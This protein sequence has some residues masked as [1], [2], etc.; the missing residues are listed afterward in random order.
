MTTTNINYPKV[1][2]YF[3]NYNNETDVV[4]GFVLPSQCMSTGMNNTFQTTSLDELVEKLKVDFN[5]DYVENIPVDI[6]PSDIIGSDPG[7][8]SNEQ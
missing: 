1:K 5:I 7:D 3:I 4:Y 2:T 8:I 6:E